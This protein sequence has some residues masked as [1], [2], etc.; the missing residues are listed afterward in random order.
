MTIR[1]VWKIAA[2]LALITIA[3][4]AAPSAQASKTIPLP[5][6]NLFPEGIAA[7]AAGGLYVSSL[8][9][10]RILYLAPGSHAPRI[11]VNDGRDGLM[12]TAGMMVTPDGETL[13]VCNSD[14]G[15][16]RFSGASKP[17]LVAFDTK[18]ASLTGRW[19][20][21]EGGVCNDLTITPNGTI[22][23]TDSLNPRI[24]A[25]TSGADKLTQWATDKRFIGE[26]FNLNGITWTKQGVFVV[27]YNSNE[28]FR[29]TSLP[30]GEAGSIDAVHLS[31][32][33]VG[34]DG[35]KTLDNGDLLVVEGGGTLARIAL[36]GL[37]GRIN[38]LGNGLNVPTTA[39]VFNGSVY[40]VE[41]QLDHLPTPGTSV[42]PPA[43]FQLKILNL[44]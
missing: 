2:G 8:T 12:S 43:P 14:L 1:N 32:P 28:L 36:N 18:T 3:S 42:T 29:I 44:Y 19:N 26:G 9:Q 7:D 15:L 25:L 11:F 16:G 23:M 10:G 24:L 5:G 33:L 37:Q 22:L 27:K 41:G 38:T 6:A 34:P 17:G 39:A 35:I 20:F 13:Y 4:T 40:V 21:P 31:R 30:G